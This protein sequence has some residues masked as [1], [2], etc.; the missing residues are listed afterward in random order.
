MSRACAV[1]PAAGLSEDARERLLA[2][3]WPDNVRKL[4]NAIERAVIFCEGGLISSEHLP[5]AIGGARESAASTAKNAAEEI[6]LSLPPGSLKL[7][8]FAREL[9]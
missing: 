9:R 2:H 4:R 3:N 6:A 1:R 7:D 5:I 8:A